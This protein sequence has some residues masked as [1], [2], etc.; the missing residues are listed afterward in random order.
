MQP[1][2]PRE[3]SQG[4]WPHSAPH[5]KVQPSGR[6][7][8]PP[9]RRFQGEPHRRYS[10]HL[11]LA[12]VE[13]RVKRLKS[14]SSHDSRSHLAPVWSSYGRPIIM[15]A[16][17]GHSAGVMKSW[18]RPYWRDGFETRIFVARDRRK[19]RVTDPL[20]PLAKGGPGGVGREPW[21]SKTTLPAS[22]AWADAVIDRAATT[23]PT[24]PSQ[25]GE[26]TTKSG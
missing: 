21:K 11:I 3:G 23:P 1:K 19:T 7:H 17:Q 20:P 2:S 25:G 10:D 5:P 16:P 12:C 14:R 9:E 26:K 22:R 8:Q 13:C 4:L 6:G 15:Q 24:P 18:C